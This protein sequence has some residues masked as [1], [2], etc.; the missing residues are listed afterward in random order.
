MLLRAVRW[1]AVSAIGLNAMRNVEHLNADWRA[2]LRRNQAADFAA[3]WELECA[4]FEEPNYRRGGWSGVYRTALRG[5]QEGDDSVG[6][7]IKRQDNHIYRS[8]RH[9]FRAMPTF[10]REFRNIRLFQEYDI[11]TVEWLY[12]GQRMVE[13]HIRSILVTQE[14]AGYLAL[15]DERLTA[16]LSRT[17]RRQLLERLAV[18]LRLMHSHHIQHGCLYPKHV[19][20]KRLADGRIDVR[21]IDL[22][23]ARY[24]YFGRVAA[25]RDISTLYRHSPHISRADK[26]FFFKAY[27]QEQTL[28][29]ASRAMLARVLRRKMKTGANIVSVP[30]GEV[31]KSPDTRE[32]NA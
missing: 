7:F 28:S 31:M 20:F 14:L 12:F 15:D 17:E 24:R 29:Q 2:L 21:L 16:V 13:G 23:K 19:F 1:R 27:R 22:E 30:A 32:E 25:L 26:L 18:V 6:V 3:L 8:L 9:G 5:L 11:P 4:W 10:E